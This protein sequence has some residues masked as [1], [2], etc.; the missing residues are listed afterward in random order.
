MKP[1]YIPH[2]IRHG[3]TSLS[4]GQEE[5]GATENE[6]VGW[7]EQLSGHKF[8]QTLGDSGGQRSLVAAVHGVAKSCIQLSDWTTTTDV[9]IHIT[10]WGL[11]ELL[12]RLLQVLMELSENSRKVEEPGRSK[13]APGLGNIISSLHPEYPHLSNSHQLKTDNPVGPKIFGLHFS[14]RSTVLKL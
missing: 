7:H 14:L 13:S 2:L 1:Q 10:L 9:E 6:M 8:E 12:W 3:H 11:S 4:W 5:K